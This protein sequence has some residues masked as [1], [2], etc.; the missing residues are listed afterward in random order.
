MQRPQEQP[1]LPRREFL[2]RSAMGALAL[3]A[4]AGDRSDA[5]AMLTRVSSDPHDAGLDRPVAG[6]AVLRGALIAVGG[7]RGE[8]AVWRRARIDGP[9]VRVAG[10]GAF[11][12]GTALTGL[13]VDA[14]R[15]V[16]VGCTGPDHVTAPAVFSSADLHAWVVEPGIEAVP[17]VL[18]GVA[19]SGHRL[20]AV[21][22]RFAEPD[23]EEPVETIAYRRRPDERWI[24]AALPGV[25]PVHHGAIT[26]LAGSDDR[27]VL[28]IT[29][30]DGLDLFTAPGIEGP[31]R[32]IGAPRAAM[33]LS[34]VAAASVRG[35]ILLAA[36][37]GLDRG[38]FW[39]RIGRSWIEVD[40]PGGIGEH[41]KV[42]GLR[43]IGPRL[44]IAGSR[45][46]HG[47]LTEVRAS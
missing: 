40:P 12:A 25:R 1:S 9:W 34:P 27:T 19:V 26:L 18:T 39:R 31:W 41:I 37:D 35:Q 43:R 42:R 8:P 38:R 15:V 3:S 7:T 21:G 29:D 46:H 30:V 47:F 13:A 11:P 2:R 28:G 44:V 5:V 16:A 33:P 32:S 23:V 22:T 4:F 20:L 6:V 36:I 17:G 10:A 45:G 14:G 24:G